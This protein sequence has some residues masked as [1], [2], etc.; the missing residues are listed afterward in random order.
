MA[1]I[2]HG[3]VRGYKSGCRCDLCTHANTKAKARERERRR[4]REGKPATVRTPRSK[5]V[6]IGGADAPTEDQPGA[7]EAAFRA[8]LSDETSDLIVIARREVVFASAR[9]M[10]NR[11]FAP[12][13][14]SNADVLQA[15][16]AALLAGQPAKDGE[17]DELASIMASFGGSSGNSRG[18]RGAP[19]VDDPKES[20]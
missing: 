7:I 9:N 10:D 12:F 2:N 1:I 6:P 13:F 19:S 18:R 16:L 11:K 20:K 17:A 3:T 14:K 5:S 8:A 15:V 4:E